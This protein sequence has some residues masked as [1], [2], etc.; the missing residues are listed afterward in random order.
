MVTFYPSK[1]R[2][3]FGSLVLIFLD[4]FLLD[5]SDYFFAKIFDSGRNIFEIFSLVKIGVQVKLVVLVVTFYGLVRDE[6]H[7]GI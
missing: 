3:P 6:Y 1:Y 2:L 4:F 5:T 7:V